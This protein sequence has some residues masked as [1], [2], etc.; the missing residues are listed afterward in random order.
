[1]G[2]DLRIASSCLLLSLNEYVMVIFSPGDS[3]T[4]SIGSNGKDQHY[5]DSGFVSDKDCSRYV[6]E[7]PEQLRDH[8]GWDEP[9]G[10]GWR[11]N[12][13]G[14]CSGALM[15]D[16]RDHQLKPGENNNNDKFKNIRSGDGAPQIVVLTASGNDTHFS[17]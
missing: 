11:K 2:S 10:T 15:K 7:W 6:K 9:Q 8:P 12:N 16:I 5:A 14:A 13:F 17:E 3:Y 4:A 1:M